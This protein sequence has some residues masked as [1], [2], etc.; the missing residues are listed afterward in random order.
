MQQADVMG[1]HVD[2]SWVEEGVQFPSIELRDQSQK[3]PHEEEGIEIPMPPPAEMHDMK[4]EFYQRAEG[5]GVGPVTSAWKENTFAW[6][7]GL[8]RELFGDT[9]RVTGLWQQA[10]HRFARRLARLQNK[11]EAQEIY[12]QVAR[13]VKLPFDKRPAT[14]IRAPKNHKDLP[15]HRQDVFDAICEQLQEGSLQGFVTRQGGKPMG[16]HALRW[17]QK[18][19]GKVRLTLNGRPINK[20]FPAAKCTVVLET[21]SQLRARYSKGQM[22]VG[23]DLHNGF[24]NQQYC[25]EDRTW[26]GFRI[27]A[28]ELGE[29]LTKKLRAKLPDSWIGDDCYFCYRGLVMGLSP[30]C[31]QLQT[32][33]NALLQ[34]WREC[35]VVGVQ[36]D[37]TNYIDDTM[38]MILGTFEGAIELTLHLLVEFIVLGYS[39]NLNDKSTIVP[40]TYYCHIG[41]LLSSTRM[42]FS[43]PARR[44]QKMVSAMRNLQSVAKVGHKVEARLVAKVV[45]QLWSANVVCFRAVAIMARGMTHTIATLIRRSDAA[46]ETDMDKLKYILKK[47]WGGSVVWSEDAHQELHFWLKVDFAKLSAPFSHDARSKEL[48]AYVLDPASGKLSRD[49]RVF[50]VDTSATMSG[51]GEFVKDG[52]LW[53][54]KSKMVA[55]LADDEVDESSTFR[56]LTGVKSLNLAA[57]PEECTKVLLPLDSQA[58]VSTVLKG[59]RV[60]KLQALAR[61]IFLDQLLHNR[62]LWPIWMR[63]C[64]LI[65]RLCDEASRLIDN[66]SFITPAAI[67]WKANRLAIRLWGRGFQ[68]DACADMHN[69][70]PCDRS[71][72]MPFYSR[73]L[74][75]HASAVDMLQ[76]DWTCALHW[77]NP[78]FFLLPRVISLLRVQKAAAAVVIP[79]NSKAAWARQARVGAHGVR[80]LFRFDWRSGECASATAAKNQHCRGAY[81]VVF[82]DFGDRIPSTFSSRQLSAESFPEGRGDRV[83]LSLNAAT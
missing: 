2:E 63:R 28:Q 14:P 16:I 78:P 50:A 76:Q 17:V 69:V 57:I 44:V 1:G 72:K 36:W 81:A 80:F 73:W 42:R 54:M 26:V 52:K 53:C 38:A 67:F 56:E 30:S 13:G 6:A 19:N 59:S 20:F 8:K 24:F 61:G 41:I 65:I 39:P 68:V 33:T 55:R 32:V 15:L 37:A 45:G 23:F 62:I 51:G 48:R 58:S 43:L 70:Q 22:Y 66:H 40:T 79:W 5:Q 74:S 47:V 27:S 3:W 12:R 49:V 71:H 9:R 64:E 35:E 4:R 18:S 60:P 77:C 10:K 7:L 31:N 11:R 46:G 25:E 82:F 21:H 75:P 83:F 29:E 34:V